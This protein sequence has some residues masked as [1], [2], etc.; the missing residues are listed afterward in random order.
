MSP[1]FTDKISFHSWE[2][3]EVF[4]RVWGW[5]ASD[6]VFLTRFS[7]FTMGKYT[8]T[9]NANGHGWEIREAQAEGQ[10]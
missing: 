6:I 2:A 8:Y 4:G 1:C 5:A 3:A 7:L 9:I 10:R